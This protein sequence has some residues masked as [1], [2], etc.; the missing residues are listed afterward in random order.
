MKH[1]FRLGLLLLLSTVIINNVNAQIFDP[2][3]WDFNSKKISDCEYELTIKA[4]IEG[5]WHLYGQKAYGD[6][7]PIPTSFHFTKSSKY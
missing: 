7:G 3:K 6:D 5:K 4:N 2:V 1:I